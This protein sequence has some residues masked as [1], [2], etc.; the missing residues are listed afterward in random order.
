MTGSTE[1]PHEPVLTVEELQVGFSVG[2]RTIRAVN[3]VSFSVAPGET[4]AIVGESGSGKSTTGL[5]LMGLIE[6]TKRIRIS[7]RVRLKSKIGRV[8]DTLELPART[9]RQVRGN[10]I[11]M[12]FQEPMSSLNPVYSIGAQ[13]AEAV[14]LHR[15]MSR[16]DSLARALELIEQLGVP[17]PDKCLVSYPHQLSGGMRQRAMIAM[18]L[19]CEP[20][21]LIA[22]EP[23]TALDVTVQAQ[24]IELL[25]QV[26][27]RTGMAIIFITHNLAI[28]SEIADRTLVM[29]AG[30]VVESVSAADLFDRP[31]MPYTA[32]LLQSLPRLDVDRPRA[33][34]LAAIPGGVPNA[35]ALPS[36]CRF[37]PRCGYFLGSTC[38]AAR[39]PLEPCA[40]GHWVRCHRWRDIGDF[41]A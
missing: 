32:A 1:L 9:L 18:A 13:I 10:D 14:A 26:Q 35:G 11:A 16:A 34:K 38:D 4:L 15:K 41:A 5:A 37:H 6:K 2:N 33:A 19:S 25:K 23:T 8:C 21:L 3:G 27:A 20:R 24:I 31:R 36:G 12:I 39:P 28:V 40:P 7:G 29:Y 22:D 17:N 30:E